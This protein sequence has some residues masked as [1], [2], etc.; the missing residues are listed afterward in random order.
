M[1][2]P[3]PVSN[4]SW[5][6]HTKSLEQAMSKLLERVLQN[7]VLEVEKYKLENGNLDANIDSSITNQQLKDIVVDAGISIDRS[8][9]SRGWSVEMKWWLWYP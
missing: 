4:V 7:V 6:A 3:R 8:W 5:T 9:N 1:N 2:L